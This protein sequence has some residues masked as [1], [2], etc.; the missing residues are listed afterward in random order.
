MQ[1]N[2]VLEKLREDLNFWKKCD[3]IFRFS[4]SMRTRFFALTSIQE[5]IKTKWDVVDPQNRQSLKN[6]VIS[7][8]NE[9][10]SKE[11]RSSEENDNLKILNGIIVELIKRELGGGWESAIRDLI[12]NAKTG[13]NVCSNNLQILRML[14]EEIFEFSKETMTSAKVTQLKARFNEDFKQIYLLCDSVI[15]TYLRDKSLKP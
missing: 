4:Q 14:S 10:A 2:Q 12:E 3:T 5:V 11:Q 13:E 6:F 9:L 15:K 8:M 1:A 7:A